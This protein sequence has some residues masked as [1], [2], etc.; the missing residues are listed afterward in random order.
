MTALPTTALAVT[1]TLLERGPLCLPCIADRSKAP[2]ADV[3]TAL[4]RLQD[5][6][7]VKSGT[8]ECGGCGTSTRVYW[9]FSRGR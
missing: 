6:V 1:K 2:V 5:N 4:V 9:L 8:G 3:E 7:I